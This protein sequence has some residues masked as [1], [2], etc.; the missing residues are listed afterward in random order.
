MPAYHDSGFV[1]REPA[2]HGLSTVLDQAPTSWEEARRL[3]GLEWE[4]VAEPMYR[5][6]AQRVSSADIA[7]PD[8]RFMTLV[9]GS[10]TMVRSDTGEELGVVGKDYTPVLNETMGE[11]LEAFIGA[12]GSAKYET[13][14]SAMGGKMVYAT[15]LL[16]EP[17]RVVGDES[18]TY[19]MAAFL[20]GHDGNSSTK[21]LPLD[22]RVVCANTFNAA[23]M[24]GDRTGLQY[25]FRHTATI[26]ERLEEVKGAL[27]NMRAEGL[28]YRAVCDQLARVKMTDAQIT[29]AVERFVNMPKPGTSTERVRDN[30]AQAAAQIKGFLSSP[31]TSDDHRSSAYGL[32]QAMGEYLDHGRKAKNTDTYVRRTL[33]TTDGGKVKALALVTK[34]AGIEL[35]LAA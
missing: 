1:V 8:G 28:K 15:V 7:L 9:E 35:A 11:L 34:V 30:A 27:A 24:L 6:V 18:L 17:F 32:F 12:E 33:L 20:N 26:G 16:D 13:A 25:T 31:S 22:F 2:W 3:G 19:S 5:F 23:S 29:D 21:V 14:G 10:K 4:P